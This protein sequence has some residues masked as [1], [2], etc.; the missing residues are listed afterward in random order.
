MEA[1]K[2][3]SETTGGGLANER[4]GGGG[5]LI[6]VGNSL[7]VAVDATAASGEAGGSSST[8]LSFIARFFSDNLSWVA[9]FLLLDFCVWE[10]TFLPEYGITELR[11]QIPYFSMLT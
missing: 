5:G 10:P 11:I 7:R 4:T 3:H 9:R 8:L 6:R 1:F 2:M